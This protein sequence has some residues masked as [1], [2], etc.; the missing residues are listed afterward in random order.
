MYT[1]FK[2]EMKQQTVIHFVFPNCTRTD[3]KCSLEVLPHP[4]LQ[5]GYTHEPT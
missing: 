5:H 3:K 1:A 2:T 4:Q